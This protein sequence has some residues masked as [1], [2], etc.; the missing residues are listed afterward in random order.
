MPFSGR[1]NVYFHGL[2]YVRTGV[3]YKSLELYEDW[4]LYEEMSYMWTGVHLR[5]GLKE[6]WSYFT[7]EVFI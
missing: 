7:T 2:R 3:L 4:V 6:D 5:T 1:C